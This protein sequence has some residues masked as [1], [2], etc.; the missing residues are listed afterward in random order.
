LLI[1]NVIREVV[2]TEEEKKK[3]KKKKKRVLPIKE[4]NS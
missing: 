1:E 4:A 2:Q 3:K